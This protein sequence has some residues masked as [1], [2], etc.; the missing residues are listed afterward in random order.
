MSDLP[1]LPGVD[2][3][4]IGG[5][6]L[7]TGAKGSLTYPFR[8]LAWNLTVVKRQTWDLPVAGVSMAALYWLVWMGDDDQW[9]LADVLAVIP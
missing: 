4:S 5:Q 1:D 7:P 6:T 3:T 8:A 9:E 2:D